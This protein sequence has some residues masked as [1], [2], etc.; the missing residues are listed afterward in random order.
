MRE[1]TLVWRTCVTL[2]LAVRDHCRLTVLDLAR[3]KLPLIGLAALLRGA[4]STACPLTTLRVLGAL[5]VSPYPG[6]DAYRLHPGCIP[7]PAFIQ[8]AYPGL[9]AYTLVLKIL[10]VAH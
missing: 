2:A 9:D 4:N 3:C 7:W 10:L 8:D 6:Q 1:C 5:L